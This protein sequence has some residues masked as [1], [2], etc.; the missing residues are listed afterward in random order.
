MNNYQGVVSTKWLQ[1]HLTNPNL[2]II[3]CRFRLNNPHWGHQ[4]YLKS[5]ILGA[6]YFDLDQDLS[7]PKQKHGGRHPLPD[8]NLF[9]HKLEQIGIIKN[10]TNVVV[11]DDFRFA[12][13]SRLW[14]LLHYLGHHK[15][16]L[17]DGGWNAWQKENLPVTGTLPELAQGFFPVQ[18]ADDLVVDIET[19]RKSLDSNTSILIDAR[20]GDRYRG[21]NEPID[22]VAGHIPGAVNLFW[23]NM[24]DSEGYFVPIE[25]QKKFWQFCQDKDQI[26]VYCGSGVTAC[27][28]IFSL[29][30]SGI[31]KP[32]LYVGGWSD[33]CSYFPI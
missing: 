5:H 23:Q 6:Y 16:F 24:T 31:K 7:S 26:I 32:R 27:V 28:N 22:P 33:W 29:E 8:L 21:E 4:Q 20:S 15:V 13:A 11:Y 12:F 17:L 2:K 10:Q 19:V 1:E 14:W 30:M 9:A 25:T 3:D 18:I